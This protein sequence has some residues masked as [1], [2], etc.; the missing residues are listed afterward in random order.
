MEKE[1]ILEMIKEEMGA[2]PPV[3]KDLSDLDINF[4]KNHFVEKERA[5]AGNS[6]NPKHK[7][8]IALGVGIT[9][10]SPDCILTGVKLA[11]KQGASKEEIFE[12][13]KVAKF[14][15]SASILSSSSKAFDW[16]NKNLENEEN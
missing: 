6:L 4:L 13:F 14:S 9:L 8:L 5:Y 3:L 1:K 16:L 10:D 7:A 15:K 2:I 11:K 12:A